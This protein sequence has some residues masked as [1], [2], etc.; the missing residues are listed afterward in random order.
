MSLCTIM[1]NYKSQIHHKVY[2]ITNFYHASSRCVLKYHVTPGLRMGNVWCRA[3][4]V[5]WLRSNQ[6]GQMLMHSSLF[7]SSSLQH[8]LF[9]FSSAT[10]PQKT[11]K[12]DVNFCYLIYIYIKFLQQNRKRKKRGH[13][14][15][16]IAAP[17][18]GRG[19]VSVLG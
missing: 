17:R 11:P 2:L 5:V 8:W 3:E 4:R 14:N 10:S 13:S 16:F 7:E 6:E 18:T 19:E 1:S 12:Q 9:H 15:S